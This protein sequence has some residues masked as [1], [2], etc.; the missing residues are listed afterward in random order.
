MNWRRA[1][2]LALWTFAF[3]LLGLFFLGTTMMGSC[4]PA[5]EGD[6]CRALKEVLPARFTVGA[7][8]IYLML[9]WLIFFR[10]RTPR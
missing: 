8:V 10:R 4:N 3:L 9:T 5:P 6:A 2:A 7:F 1:L